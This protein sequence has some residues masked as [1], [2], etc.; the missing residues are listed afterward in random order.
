[1]GEKLRHN[2]HVQ[3][4]NREAIN[5]LHGSSLQS[6]TEKGDIG[7]C[8]SAV[9]VVDFGQSMFEYLHGRDPSVLL[10][11]VNLPNDLV[12]RIKRIG[13]VNPYHFDQLGRSVEVQ[14]V[15]HVLEKVWSR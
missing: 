2:S 13:H 15:L 11:E 1:M 9:R 6:I 5:A 10:S 14:L 12:N 3:L 4:L 7:S 8:T